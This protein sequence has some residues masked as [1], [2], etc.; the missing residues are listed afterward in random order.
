MQIASVI[1]QLLFFLIFAPL[2]FISYYNVWA[3]FESLGSWSIVNTKINVNSRLNYFLETQL[4]SL[5]FYN[6]FHYYE[7]KS[8]VSYKLHPQVRASIGIGRYMTYAEHGNFA[9]PFNSKE[10]RLWPQLILLHEIKHLKIEHRYRYELRLTN[11]NLK[12]RY[13]I[14]TAIFYYFGPRRNGE[15]IYQISLSNELFFT[16]KKHYFERNRF[17]LALTYA[18][19]AQIDFQIGYIYQFDYMLFD[20]IGRNFLVCGIFFDLFKKNLPREFETKDL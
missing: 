2:C 17:H 18:A 5:K 16:D 19:F 14:R 6:N 1:K 12:N 4:R 13:R 9:R 3:Q 8:G 10:L 15:K 7:I 11:N 20:E